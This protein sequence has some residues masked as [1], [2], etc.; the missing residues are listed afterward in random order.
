MSGCTK[1]PHWAACFR[2]Q[3]GRRATVGLLNGGADE[4]C[5]TCVVA[6]SDGSVQKRVPWII[7]VQNK[8]ETDC[9]PLDIKR[10]KAQRTPAG[11][12][13]GTDRWC[14]FRSFEKDDPGSVQPRSWRDF[15]T[16][17]RIALTSGI[18]Q[19]RFLFRSQRLEHNLTPK[20]LSEREFYLSTILYSPRAELADAPTALRPD[21]KPHRIDLR[22]S[23]GA[24]NIGS[25]YADHR[26]P[27]PR[28]PCS[29]VPPPPATTVVLIPRKLLSG[30]VVRRETR[31]SLFASL[32]L[33]DA[34]AKGIWR[35]PSSNL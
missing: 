22:D 4:S 16:R 20:H 32:L 24:D 34:T 26:T 5:S 14:D 7:R 10:S 29:T 33:A 21:D 31:R 8:K 1:S 19:F 27:E 6:S 28:P 35:V 25:N 2:S 18:R 11:V 12:S 30:V 9:S 3:C 17:T 15:R 23:P 13:C